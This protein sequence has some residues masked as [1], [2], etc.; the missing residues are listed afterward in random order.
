MLDWYNNFLPSEKVDAWLLALSLAIGVL[1][2]VINRKIIYLNFLQILP[3][4]FS[5]RPIAKLLDDPSFVIVTKAEDALARIAKTDL[6]QFYIGSLGLKSA[7]TESRQWAF[8]M[9]VSS[10]RNEAKE[11]IVESLLGDI[12]IRPLSQL[13]DRLNR[14]ATDSDTLYQFGAAGIRSHSW[15]TREWAAE[16]R[17][18]CGSPKAIALLVENLASPFSEIKYFK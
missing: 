6:L 3:C 2:L 11:I 14:Y 15:Q 18:K 16:M 13:R 8:D 5:I 17:G 1:F 12:A 9:I 4:R 7:R 10:G